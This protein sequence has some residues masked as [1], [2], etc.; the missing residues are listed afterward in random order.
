M[1]T[2]GEDYQPYAYRLD[3]LDLPQTHIKEVKDSYTAQAFITTDL[4][5]NQITAFHPGAMN[6]SHLNHVSDANEVSLGII[7]PDGREGMLSHAQEFEEAHEHERDD[8]Q[9]GQH[10][11]RLATAAGEYPVEHLERIKRRH[12]QQQV[13]EEAEDRGVNEEGPEPGQEFA[14]RVGGRADDY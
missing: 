8:P 12:Q 2:V 10:G 1:A 9:Q 7:A 3:R 6:F 11:K 14:H 4:D 13:D 5:D